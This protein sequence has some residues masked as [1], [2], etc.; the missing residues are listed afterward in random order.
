MWVGGGQH[1]G[2]RGREQAQAWGAWARGR[3]HEGGRETVCR[4]QRVVT[5]TGGHKVGSRQE[6]GRHWGASGR[7]DRQGVR[8]RYG[9][10]DG[11]K[12]SGGHP[13]HH[14]SLLLSLLQ[15]GGGGGFK[16]TFC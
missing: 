7:E 2:T 6:E 3:L 12:A 1:R 8:H 10:R 5:G 11:S 14:P 13:G 16:T 9:D 15:R 4:Q